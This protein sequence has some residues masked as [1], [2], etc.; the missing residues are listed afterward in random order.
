MAD[1]RL[2][3]YP[4]TEKFNIKDT[5]GVPHPFMI[6]QHHVGFA[7]DNYGGMLNQSTFENYEKEKGGASCGVRG[8]NLMYHE[9]EQALLVEVDS[10]QE[11]NEVEGLQ[12]YLL[13]CKKQCEADGFAGFA[14]IKKEV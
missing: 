11:L 1:E 6:T 13:S 10:D 3:N 5:I 7:G 9:H 2:E 4:K 14:F 8:C 12:E